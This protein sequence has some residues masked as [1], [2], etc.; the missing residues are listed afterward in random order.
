M[1]S[2][3]LAPANSGSDSKAL[4]VPAS[5]CV[6]VCSYTTRGSAAV[7]ATAAFTAR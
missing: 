5:V 4:T 6:A 1:P 3:V 2:S 7:R